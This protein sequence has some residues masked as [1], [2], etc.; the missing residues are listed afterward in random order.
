MLQINFIIKKKK[1]KKK[2]TFDTVSKYYNLFEVKVLKTA[3]L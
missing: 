3:M 1:K 2:I